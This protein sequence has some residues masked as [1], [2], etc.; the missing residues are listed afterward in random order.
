[1]EEKYS[2]TEGDLRKKIE[3]L[4]VNKPS[5]EI[6]IYTQSEEVVKEFYK[7]LREEFERRAKGSTESL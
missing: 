4:M 6:I 5:D 1:M 7:A 3:E 2:I